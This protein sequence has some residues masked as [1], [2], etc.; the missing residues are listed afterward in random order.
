MSRPKHRAGRRGILLGSIV[1]M[2]L[3]LGQAGT[4]PARAD[5]PIG[6]PPPGSVDSVQPVIAVTGSDVTIATTNDPNGAILPGS[7]ITYTLTV[8]N[9]G[10]ATAATVGVTDQLPVGVSF[11]DATAGC[12]EAAAVVTCALGD[13]GAGASLAVDITVTV[14]TASC[15]AIFNSADVSASNESG[16][17]V[18]NNASNE[19]SNNVECEE[20]T[21]P[22]LQVS[23]RS[24]ADGILR[25]GDDFLYTITVANVGEEEARGVELVDVLPPSAL[26]V[27][28]PPFPTFGGKACTVTSSAPPDGLSHAE[29]RCGPISLDPGETASVTVKVFVSG[30]ICG[31]ITNVV[32]VE[33]ANEPAGNVGSDNRAESTDEIACVPRIRLRKDGPSLAHVGDTITYAFTARNDG[34]VDLSNLDLND[35]S[36]HTSPALIDD[37]DGDDVLSVDE[38]WRFGCDQTIT[39]G[40]GD[41]VHTQATVTGD[42]EDGTVTDSDTHDAN[43]IHPSIDLEKTASPTS[44]PAGTRIVYTYTVTNTGDTPLFDVSVHDDEAGHVGE[45]AKLT[46]GQTV[47]LTHQITLG[48]SPIIS[49]GTAAATDLLGASVS[50]VDDARVAAVSGE[51]GGNDTGGG[52]PF[53]GFGAGALAGWTL[54]LATLGTAILATSRKRSE[55]QG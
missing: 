47:E 25:D 27:G 54:V 3:A 14:D 52:S 50:D 19:V 41:P 40:D 51:G 33:G 29:V 16:E 53:T 13:T 26:N 23:K 36:C 31:S 43:V 32:D 35:P 22:D 1:V 20:P 30:D 45:I 17:A 6:S 15:G 9:H 2:M 18:G 5:P 46:A 11:V 10:D 28:V 21:P 34:S 12:S 49:V 39:A 8:T 7:S 42:H 55:T 48:S 4:L 44:G 37:G 24:D 38:E